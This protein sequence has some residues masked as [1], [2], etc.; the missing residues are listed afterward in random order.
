MACIG[1]STRYGPSLSARAAAASS[2]RW[3]IPTSTA[4]PAIGLLEPM[5]TTAAVVCSRQRFRGRRRTGE[6]EQL[7]SG[8]PG[9]DSGPFQRRLGGF[10]GQVRC[11]SRL[12]PAH[13]ALTRPALSLRRLQEI[14]S[15]L[16]L[17]EL[18][19]QVEYEFVCPG[20]LDG[21]IGL[22]LAGLPHLW[23]LGCCGLH[24]PDARP[25]RGFGAFVPASATACA[26]PAPT[27]GAAD[28]VLEVGKLSAI[29]E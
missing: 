27:H 18:P 4:V 16:F 25:T 12:V 21:G 28:R 5:H 2:D 7:S 11:G 8:S 29:G 13:R 3:E 19:L 24:R 10:L 26:P 15:R 23:G 1:P 17:L 14:L 9:L 6:T 20:S 22:R